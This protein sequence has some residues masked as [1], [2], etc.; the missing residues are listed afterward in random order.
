MFIVADIED[1]K[2]LKVLIAK[3]RKQVSV[4]EIKDV[5][6]EQV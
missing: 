2:I 1:E 3:L 4:L 6:P 5:T